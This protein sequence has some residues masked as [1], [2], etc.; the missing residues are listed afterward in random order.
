[1]SELLTIDDL[2]FWSHKDDYGPFIKVNPKLETNLEDLCAAKEE[3]VLARMAARAYINQPNN[4]KIPSLMTLTNKRLLI[5]RVKGTRGFMVKTMR[6]RMLGKL[7]DLAILEI[8]DYT[9]KALDWLG[10][11]KTAKKELNLY[12]EL[13]DLTD[14]TILNNTE[15]WKVLYEGEWQHLKSAIK[16]VT[17]GK[18]M[19]QKGTKTTF[20]PLKE[21]F[22]STA[23]YPTISFVDEGLETCLLEFVALFSDVLASKGVSFKVQPDPTCA[24]Q[25]IAQEH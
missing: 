6:D 3:I 12:I 21:K 25:I 8:G 18:A 1:M 4:E 24:F 5:H 19:F 17:M 2:D 23:K 7:N 16:E 10:K 9:V 20:K 22:F 11:N 14:D 13:N 15:K